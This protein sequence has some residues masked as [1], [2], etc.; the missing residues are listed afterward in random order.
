MSQLEDTLN[1][2]LSDPQ[3]MQKLLSTA[4]SLGLS[5]E[6]Q[7]EAV[8][9]PAAPPAFSL[10][11]GLDLGMLQKLSGFAGQA[12]VDANQKSLLQALGPY[13]SRNRLQKLER[14]MRAAKMASLAT[15]LIGR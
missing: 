6:G 1:Q 14:A 3:M 13:I 11:E 7:K 8:P 10:P 2:V 4:Q 15:S 9:K 5:Q 12:G